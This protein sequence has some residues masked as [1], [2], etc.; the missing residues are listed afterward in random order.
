MW[1][2]LL[3]LLLVGFMA[4]LTYNSIKHNPQAF[5]KDN[6]N[7]SF[8]LLGWLA[9]GLIGFVALLVFLLKTG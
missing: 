6:L 1:I 8:Y 7:K 4:W 9:L 3:L 5:T 2:K